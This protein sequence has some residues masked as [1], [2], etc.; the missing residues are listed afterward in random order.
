MDTTAETG[1]TQAK[2]FALWR[3][4]QRPQQASS[5]RNVPHQ[6][7]RISNVAGAGCVRETK[8]R[9][10]NRCSIRTAQSMQ[11]EPPPPPTRR[12]PQSI[13]ITAAKVAVQIAGAPTQTMARERCLQCF[14]P[15]GARR[16]HPHAGKGGCAARSEQGKQGS[17]TSNARIQSLQNGRTAWSPP[18]PV[19]GRK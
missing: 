5:C 12:R 17:N 7:D 9:S 1:T 15:L 13:M 16:S 14:G 11:G 2:E 19:N 6:Q 10:Q 3:R 18:P 4:L 8:M